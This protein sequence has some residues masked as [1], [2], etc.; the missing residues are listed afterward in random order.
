MLSVRDWIIFELLW[1]VIHRWRRLHVSFSLQTSA[2]IIQLHCSSQKTYMGKLHLLV[3]RDNACA[4]NMSTAGPLNTPFTLR[5]IENL[6]ELQFSA[7]WKIFKGVS[8]QRNWRWYIPSKLTEDRHFHHGSIEWSLCLME[9][10][11]LF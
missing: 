2:S 1:N 5:Q 6:P 11:C 7:F 3:W 9:G 4:S 8:T 10:N